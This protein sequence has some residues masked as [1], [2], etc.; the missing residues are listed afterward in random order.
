MIA[1]AIRDALDVALARACLRCGDR[2]AVLCAICE[3]ALS[4]SPMVTRVDGVPVASCGAYS[5][6]LRDAI[7][8][9]KVHGSRALAPALARLLAVAVVLADRVGA[10]CDSPERTMVVPIPGH[11]RPA[12]GFAALDDITRHLPPSLPAHLAVTPILALARGY[13]PVKG[14]SRRARAEAVRGSMLCRE[15]RAPLQ[16]AILI[17][18][19]LTTG[20]TVRE[21]MR[22]LSARGITTVAIAVLASPGTRAMPHAPARAT[23][24][25]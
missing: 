16:R 17:D 15:H 11:A 18:D 9:Y 5:G 1:S 21:G 12:R 3:H 4:A 13:R 19:V 8:D 25:R 24:P 20:A 23:L 22:A 10:S 6:A 14:Q 7:L 2:G